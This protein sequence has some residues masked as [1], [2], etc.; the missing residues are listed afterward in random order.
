MYGCPADKQLALKN[1]FTSKLFYLTQ[2]EMQ[3]ELEAQGLYHAY[4]N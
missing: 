4:V 1:S 3:A 2:E